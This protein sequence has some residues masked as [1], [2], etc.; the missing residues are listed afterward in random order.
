MMVAT[1]ARSVDVTP[2]I[3]SFPQ[4]ARV[5]FYDWQETQAQALARHGNPKNFTLIQYVLV[6]PPNL[7]EAA[8]GH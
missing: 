4:P 3:E 6:D 5:A 7:P 8:R 1:P 2:A